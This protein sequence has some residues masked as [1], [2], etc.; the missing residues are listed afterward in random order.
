MNRYRIAFYYDYDINP[1]SR[2]I[3]YLFRHQTD[4]L[5]HALIRMSIELAKLGHEVA[6]FASAN[7]WKQIREANMRT[8]S[9]DGVVDSSRN[10]LQLFSPVEIFEVASQADYDIV[11][12]V[13][14]FRCFYA[15]VPAKYR[16]LWC[17]HQLD[18]RNALLRTL[19]QVDELFMVSQWQLEHYC[20]HFPALR[21]LSWV[22][23]IGID[24]PDI[25]QAS[26]IMPKISR[27]SVALYDCSVDFAETE[28]Q[29]LC[30]CQS[31][32]SFQAGLKICY[33]LSKL[34]PFLKLKFY[35][36][37]S[38]SDRTFSDWQKL[39][40]KDI[41]HLECVQYTDSQHFYNELLRSKIV[42]YPEW[43]PVSGE[44]IGRLTLAIQA[45]MRPIVCIDHPLFQELICVS[46]NRIAVESSRGYEDQFVGRVLELLDNHSEYQRTVEKNRE[47][48]AT[49]QYSVLA[50]KWVNHFDEQFEK[51][52][53]SNKTAIFHRLV[54]QEDIEAARRLA[55]Q[56]DMEEQQE[57]VQ[58]ILACISTH[59][60]YSRRAIEPDKEKDSQ[61]FTAAISLV[62]IKPTR[63]LDFA[64]GNGSMIYNLMTTYPNAS[65]VGIDFSE[66]LVKRAQQYINSH[67]RL[68]PARV[69][70]IV[71]TEADIPKRGFD[72]IF[73]GE[74][75]EHL[76]NPENFVDY[77]ESFLVPQGQIIYTVPH[78]P[79]RELLPLGAPIYTQH[80]H[81]F[82]VRDIVALFGSKYLFSMHYLPGL[83]SWQGH[84]TGHYL[85]TYSLPPLT[86]SS[87][88]DVSSKFRTGSLDYERKFR[89]TRPYWDLSKP[90]IRRN[91]SE[92][93]REIVYSMENMCAEIEISLLY[94]PQDLKQQQSIQGKARTIAMFLYD[95]W[96]KIFV[97]NQYQIHEGTLMR[98]RER[99]LNT[100]QHALHLCEMGKMICVGLAI[101]EEMNHTRPRVMRF[102]NKDDLQSYVNE[103]KTSIN[104]RL[105]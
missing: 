55:D 61:R 57:D 30:L 31:E 51:R 49:Y 26:D 103:L 75:L 13:Q 79:F 63:I 72:L 70:F 8:S 101:G 69:E 44:G 85:I 90:I 65:I 32:H 105:S 33:K 62:R 28:P 16:V 96:K 46:A 58:S 27:D 89:L 3:T 2:N 92:E 20:Y 91:T 9:G 11:I 17:H 78:G 74:Y 29:L 54:W 38:V 25:N 21:K 12:S 87:E 37:S 82:E 23:G 68:N 36:D 66:E 73:V 94:I 60:D 35:A 100:A 77:I 59:Q 76:Q 10:W 84:A 102:L 81:N 15:P 104:S 98:W 50:Q 64:C 1:T 19:C 40:Q 6:V 34:R 97:E 39:I 24:I 7:V 80:L 93:L 99:A 4:E 5:E 18:D 45:C 48:I 83:F 22:A 71:G 47:W 67:E 42:L 43:D 88:T 86:N 41:H 95:L 14:S 56:Y 53:Q 52:F